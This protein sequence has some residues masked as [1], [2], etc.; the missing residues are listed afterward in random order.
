MG[1]EPTTFSLGSWVEIEG[2]LRITQSGRD[3]MG[4]S[5]PRRELP[6]QPP[7]RWAGAGP[8]RRTVGKLERFGRT[9]MDT[10]C[11]TETGCDILGHAWSGEDIGS[12][13]NLGRRG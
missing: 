2:R 12:S 11:Q 13:E 1:L 5:V 3:P 7:N 6:M 9:A 4:R 10:G 8:A